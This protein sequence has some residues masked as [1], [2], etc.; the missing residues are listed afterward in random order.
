MGIVDD[1][2][3]IIYISADNDLVDDTRSGSRW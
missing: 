2:L 1:I 3:D